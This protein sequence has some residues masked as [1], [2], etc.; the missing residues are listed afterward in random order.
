M[1]CWFI[2]FVQL[3]LAIVWYHYYHFVP[4][5]LILLLSLYLS[6]NFQYF[7]SYFVMN[8]LIF[9]L[10]IGAS[11]QYL[12]ALMFLIYRYHRI[13]IIIIVSFSDI[14]T[15]MLFRFYH[16]VHH[17]I[18]IREQRAY[19]LTYQTLYKCWY[20]LDLTKSKTGWWCYYCSI[21]TPNFFE[22]LLSFFT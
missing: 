14:F 16:D 21:L 22:L 12:T 7:F 2:G 6:E 17:V 20:W 18:P 1:P 4:I 11:T 9:I 5:I 15:H 10:C 8:S 3:I 19:N 13:I